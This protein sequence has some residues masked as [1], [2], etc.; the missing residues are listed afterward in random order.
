MTLMK[1]NPTN[2]DTDKISTTCKRYGQTYTGT[3]KE[4]H[5]RQQ[6]DGYEAGNTACKSAFRERLQIQEEQQDR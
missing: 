3:E 1:K 5:A 4:G 2:L 6:E